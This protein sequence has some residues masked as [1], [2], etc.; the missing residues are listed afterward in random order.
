M[1]DSLVLT[2]QSLP[3][4][5]MP[6]PCG[7]ICIS[8]FACVRL[9]FEDVARIYH[10]S[11]PVYLLP[12]WFSTSTPTSLPLAPCS[13]CSMPITTVQVRTFSIQRGYMEYTY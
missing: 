11:I 9:F 3:S 2:S 5:A 12:K 13:P 10:Q 7:G 4:T 6:L 8:I 1:D